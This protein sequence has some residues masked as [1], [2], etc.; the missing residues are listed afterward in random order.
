MEGERVPD[1][2]VGAEA[3]IGGAAAIQAVRSAVGRVV[4]P[5][6]DEIS[7]ALGRYTAF[8]LRNVGRI[9]E[10]ADRKAQASGREG[11]VPPRVGPPAAR[12]GLVLR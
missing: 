4:G 6:T 5:A 3:L 9:A 11:D 2:I 12:G 10:N 7:A 8:R 1:P